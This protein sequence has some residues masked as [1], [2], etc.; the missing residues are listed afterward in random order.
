[1]YRHHFAR[2]RFSAPWKPSCI[3]QASFSRLHT[4]QAIHLARLVAFHTAQL[5]IR[6]IQTPFIASIDNRP[7]LSRADLNLLSLGTVLLR[8][9]INRASLLILHLLNKLSDAKEVVHFLESQA[10]FAHGSAT[11]LIASNNRVLASLPWSQERG[12]RRR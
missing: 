1:M 9:K 5:F 6:L 10:L 11:D 3:D 7:L 8:S 4:S 2:I 12:T